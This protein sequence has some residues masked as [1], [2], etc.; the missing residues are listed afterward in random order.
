MKLTRIILFGLGIS[1]LIAVQSLWAQAGIRQ[2]KKPQMKLP[3]VSLGIYSS[4]GYAANTELSRMINE[5]SEAGRRTGH[6]A[7]ASMPANI[8]Y[9]GGAVLR[10]FANYYPPLR[11]LGIQVSTDFYFFENAETGIAINGDP[12]QE[13]SFKFNAHS[14]MTHSAAFIFNVYRSSGFIAH[15]GTGVLLTQETF[16]FSSST[17]TASASFDVSGTSFGWSWFATLEFK[18]FRYGNLFTELHLRYLPVSKLTA[19][20]GQILQQTK[21]TGLPASEKNATVLELKDT[22]EPEDTSWDQNGLLFRIG[23]HFY[24]W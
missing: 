6:Y 8:T 2:R 22:S 17:P 15:L 5:V 14:A 19:S 16:T 10:H 11:F 4:G 24:Y 1:C 7:T 20:N 21:P 18:L 9:G 13:I 3:L 12:K 23:V